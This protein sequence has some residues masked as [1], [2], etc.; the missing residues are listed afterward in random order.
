MVEILDLNENFP[1]PFEKSTMW[2]RTQV[3][4]AYHGVINIQPKDL[5]VDLATSGYYR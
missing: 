1:V 4:W 5:A 3:M 2:E